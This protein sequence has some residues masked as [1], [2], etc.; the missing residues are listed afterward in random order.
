MDSVRHGAS[1][2]DRAGPWRC[3][4]RGRWRVC[5][6]AVLVARARGGGV[7]FVEEFVVVDVDFVWVETDNGPVTLVHCFDLPDMLT[8]LDDI[9]IELVPETYGAEFGAGKFRQGVKGEA[10]DGQRNGI[11]EDTK[12]DKAQRGLDVE[13][14]HDGQSLNE[15]GSKVKTE[16]FRHLIPY[17][18]TI[19]EIKN[20]SDMD[21]IAHP[22]MFHDR[23][24]FT[25]AEADHH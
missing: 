15:E 22:Y 1:G 6:P 9:V 7:D 25:S 5:L 21:E 14:D 19:N 16:A 12:T 3:R 23:P 2:G 17:R 11:E 20:G 8:A 13:R 4:S 18:S 10:V 24:A